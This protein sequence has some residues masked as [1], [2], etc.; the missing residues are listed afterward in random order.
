MKLLYSAAKASSLD[1]VA[2]T[3]ARTLD[4]GKELSRRFPLNL[5]AGE[6]SKL[7][8]FKLY[9]VLRISE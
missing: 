1:L 3:F 2:F 7:S 9:Q 4:L 5:L 6:F 8:K